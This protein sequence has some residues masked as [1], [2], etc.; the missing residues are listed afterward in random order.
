VADGETPDGEAVRVQALKDAKM[1]F[2]FLRP[3]F[4]FSAFRF[5]FVN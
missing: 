4:R 1:G 3:V 2:N 5:V